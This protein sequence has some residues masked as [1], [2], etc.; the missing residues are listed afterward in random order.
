MISLKDILKEASP[1]SNVKGLKGYAA[2]LDPVVWKRYKAHLAKV[3]EKTTG[4]LMDN[5]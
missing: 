5:K 2:F 3:I 1:T 4:Y